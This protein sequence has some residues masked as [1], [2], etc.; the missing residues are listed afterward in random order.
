MDT[1]TAGP[2][3]GK[4][5]GRKPEMVRIEITR[6]TVANG[7]PHD[8]GDVLEVPARDARILIALRKAKSAEKKADPVPARDPA[9]PPEV[10]KAK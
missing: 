8:V 5:P 3:V 4:N 7:S 10:K 1:K 9:K 2:L 6:R